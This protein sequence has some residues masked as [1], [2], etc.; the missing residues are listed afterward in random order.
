VNPSDFDRCY[1]CLYLARIFGG[2]QQQFCGSLP[3]AALLIVL[4]LVENEAAHVG[5]ARSDCCL[6]TRL[7]D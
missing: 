7:A 1:R 5:K 6:A 2:L 3:R 4:G